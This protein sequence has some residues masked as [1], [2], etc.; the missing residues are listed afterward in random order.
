MIRR[1]YGALCS[2]TMQ[3]GRG[4]PA[5]NPQS[6]PAILRETVRSSSVSSTAIPLSRKGEFYWLGLKDPGWTSVEPK[7]RPAKPDVATTT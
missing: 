7:S 6:R 5:H 2:Q 3:V 4:S 1:Y